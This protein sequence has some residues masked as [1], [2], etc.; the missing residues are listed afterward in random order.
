MEFAEVRPYQPGDDV[1][2]IDWRVT[3]RTQETY[4]KLF[5]EEKERPVFVLVDQRPNMFFG[6]RL[7][8]KSVLAAEIASFIAWCANANGDRI[9]AL[10]FSASKQFDLR[11][12]Q[13]KQA[14]IHFI[15]S[16]NEANS[17]LSSPVETS[18]FSLSDML[19]EVNRV[20]RSGS[21]VYLISDFYDLDP[22]T[23]AILSK[24]G[25]KSDIEFIQVID[26]V[27]QQLPPCSFSLSDGKQNLYIEKNNHSARNQYNESWQ[28]QQKHL[29]EQA[30]MARA[31]YRQARTDQPLTQQLTHLFSRK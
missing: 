8:F 29:V 26:P 21:L 12:K 25:K 24:L 20:A 1:R 11:A 30:K 14:I 3:A 16:L 17:S 13:G 19:E 6:S 15:Q 28:A 18:T 23:T 9:G 2:N 27:E 31:R 10:I 4:T 7:Q 5:Q 22:D